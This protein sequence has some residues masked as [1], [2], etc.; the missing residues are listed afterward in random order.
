MENTEAA[1]RLS[2]PIGLMAGLVTESLGKGRV[3]FHKD[4]HYDQPSS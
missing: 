2:H 3:P 1:H 4:L